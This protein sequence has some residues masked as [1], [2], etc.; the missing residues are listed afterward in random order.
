MSDAEAAY[1]ALDVMD[2][3]RTGGFTAMRMLIQMVPFMNARIQG[4]DKVYRGA[5]DNPK[6]FVVRGSILMAASLALLARNWDDER[7]EELEEWDKDTYFHIWA[8]DDTALPSAQAFRDR[9]ALFSTVPERFIRRIM[10]EE[11][12]RQTGEAML[13]MVSDTFAMNPMPQAAMPFLEQ[14]ANYNFFTGRPV[15]GPGLDRSNAGG[16]RQRRQR[17]ILRG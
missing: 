5:K 14:Y 15:V 16:R 9:G 1:R 4:I 8:G 6:A 2:F 3:S 7:Y 13:R 10:G 12:N 11:N 17:E